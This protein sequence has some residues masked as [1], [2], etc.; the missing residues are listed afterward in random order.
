MSKEAK[1]NKEA[2]INQLREYGYSDE[3]VAGIIANLDVE[4]GGTFDYRTTQKGVGGKYKPAH[5]VFQFDPNGGKYQPYMNWLKENKKKD[6]LSNQINFFH[7]T[8]YGDSQGVVGGKYL[9]PIKE[10]MES[11]TPEEVAESLVKYWF[12]AGTPH[13]DR[14]LASAA[15]TYKELNQMKDTQPEEEPFYNE[16][17]NGA[18]KG[19]DWVS[20]TLRGAGNIVKNLF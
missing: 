17:L 18:K 1:Q 14:R 7:D 10:A 12:I 20:D 9:K 8:I 6:S 13:L 3:A 11:G 15:N 4:T 19:G 2:I 16:L 5:G